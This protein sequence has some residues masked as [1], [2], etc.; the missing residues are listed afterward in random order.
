MNKA[1]TEEPD[2]E[3][4]EPDAAEQA[5]LAQ[6]AGVAGHEGGLL[7]DELEGLALEGEPRVAQVGERRSGGP[8]RL[9]GLGP[10]G[11][12][13]TGPVVGTAVA[14]A[15]HLRA[16][17]LNRGRW[18]RTWRRSAALAFQRRW[19][20]CGPRLDDEGARRDERGELR[21]REIAPI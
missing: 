11:V 14:R 18:D 8:G 5:A 2:D 13:G 7:D 15:A 20:W 10:P 1:F 3:S 4:D 16:D 12:A 9:D 17:F 21:V 19:H 6:V